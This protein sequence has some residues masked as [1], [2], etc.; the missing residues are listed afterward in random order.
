[1]KAGGI[2]NR[3]SAKKGGEHQNRYIWKII[4]NLNVTSKVLKTVFR[5]RKEA[6]LNFVEFLR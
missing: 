1:M 4:P 3:S 5:D 6:D 2:K